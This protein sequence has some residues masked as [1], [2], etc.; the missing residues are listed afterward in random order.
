MLVAL[1]NILTWQAIRTD[2][3]RLFQNGGMAQV[4]G[5]LFGRRLL[6]VVA[7][8]AALGVAGKETERPIFL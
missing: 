6:S 3:P 7:M 1:S 8:L 2:P 5:L 4:F